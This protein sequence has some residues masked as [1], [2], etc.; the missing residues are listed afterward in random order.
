MRGN[1]QT[2]WRTTELIKEI[3]TSGE[4]FMLSRS[5][6]AHFSYS[7]QLPLL[8]VLTDPQQNDNHLHTA[9]HSRSRILNSPASSCLRSGQR[10]VITR[11]H[12]SI[13]PYGSASALSTCRFEFMT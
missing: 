6:V 9:C 12:D 1:K 8:V 4:R 10:M 3:S 13:A 7:K 5:E 2:G 11:L